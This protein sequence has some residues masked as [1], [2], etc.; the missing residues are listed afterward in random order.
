MTVHQMIVSQIIWCQ[1]VPVEN[2]EGCVLVLPLGRELLHHGSAVEVVEG[3]EQT[4]VLVASDDDWNLIQCWEPFNFTGNHVIEVFD[5]LNKNIPLRKFVE[6]NLLKI[7]WGKT[8]P[9][10]FGHLLE[11]AT[12]SIEGG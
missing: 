10:F 6:L 2:E 8:L 5:K 1:I 9:F 4:L 11:V 3:A 7:Y 12:L